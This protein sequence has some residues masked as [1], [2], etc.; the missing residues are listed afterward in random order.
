MHYLFINFSIL[1]S[2]FLNGRSHIFKT[3]EMVFSDALP[4][5]F[6]PV[7]CQTHNEHQPDGVHYRC[8]C[9]PWQCDDEIIIQFQDDPGISF[10]LLVFEE[11]D[12]REAIEFDEIST[13]V[14]QLT[15]TPTSDDSPEYCDSFIQLKI[16]QNAGTQ[17]VILPDLDEWLTSS[18]SGGSPDWTLG[19]NPTVSI[20]GASAGSPITTENLYV[21]FSFT[22]GVN[23]TLDFIFTRVTDS[24]TDNPRVA[25][26]KITDSSFN[27]QFSESISA[28]DGPNPIQIIFTANASSQRI[29][30]IYTSGKDITLTAESIEGSRQLGVD[31]I[32]AKTDCLHILTE[33]KNTIYASYS[34]HRNYAGLIY[35][36]ISPAIVFKIRIPAIFFHQRFPEE[37]ETILL[38][39]QIVTLSGTMRKQRLLSVDYVPYYFHEKIMLILK[40]NVEI[41]DFTWVKQEAYQ[42]TEGDRRSPWKKAN[43]YLSRQDFVQ[44]NVL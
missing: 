11:E 10:S 38:T 36:D 30:F 27:T 7:N 6:W 14:Y 16:Q 29:A 28:V 20:V 40:Q 2:L 31:T 21:D 44:R 37:D 18:D 39:D 25:T 15:F 41:F 9:Q 26:L 13:G 35:S 19:A 5:Q 4:V 33:H 43:V 23:Y 32:L 1:A 12:Q 22:P 24:G 3:P 34:Y 42:M 17:A 8:F